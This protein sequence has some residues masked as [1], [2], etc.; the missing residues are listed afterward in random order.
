MKVSA[1][2]FN[3]SLNPD[4]AARHRLARRYIFSCGVIE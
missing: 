3:L 4:A 1:E 2:K